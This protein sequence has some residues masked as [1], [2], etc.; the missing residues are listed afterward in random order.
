M[1]VDA[2]NFYLTTPMERKEYLRIPV[3]LI[4]QEFMDTYK[5]HEKVKNG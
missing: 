4:L 2:G 3:A 1:T 5:L